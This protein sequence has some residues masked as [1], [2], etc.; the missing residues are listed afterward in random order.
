MIDLASM[1]SPRLL[2][3]PIELVRTLRAIIEPKL[4]KRYAMLHETFIEARDA[5]GRLVA[6]RYI[7]GKLILNNFKNWIGGALGAEEYLDGAI[8]ETR[9]ASMVDMGGVTRSIAV[10]YVVYAMDRFSFQ[11]RTYRTENFAVGSR[12]RIGTGTIAPARSDYALE[13]EYAS[14]IPTVTI[15][16]DYVAWSV[17]IT[18]VTGATITEAGLS[19]KA[20]G[21]YDILL[22]RDVF[23]GVSV[24][25]GG[26]ISVTIKVTM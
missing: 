3:N 10:R 4:T 12:T 11:G 17:G 9:Y 5:K 24:P 15:G 7:K 13:A 20:G 8:D 16:A 18:L 14:G 23:A 25:D 1:I 22:T 2:L 26:T 21:A 19:Q 6:R